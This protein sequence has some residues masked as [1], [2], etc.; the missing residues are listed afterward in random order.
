MDAELEATHYSYYIDEDDSITINEEQL[1]ASGLHF[2]RR[3]RTLGPSVSPSTTTPGKNCITYSAVSSLFCPVATSTPHPFRVS[4]QSTAETGL[5]TTQQS[6]EYSA[7]DE[8][9]ASG[10]FDSRSCS[11]KCLE[12]PELV[13]KDLANVTGVNIANVK[14][15]HACDGASHRGNEI[16]SPPCFNAEQSGVSPLQ[17]ASSEVLWYSVSPDYWHSGTQESFHNAPSNM[18]SQNSSALLQNVVP[19]RCLPH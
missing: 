6:L 16:E 1:K 3:Y 9:T 5:E 15:G 19:T 14:P 8:Q 7:Q 13:N 10:G 12:M 18:T 4:K 11:P 17:Q 2:V